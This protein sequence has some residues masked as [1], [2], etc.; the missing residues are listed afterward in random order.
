MMGTEEES[1]QN[2]SQHVMNFQTTL[3]TIESS[4]GEDTLWVP[5]IWDIKET[6]ITK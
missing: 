2:K 4:K 3:V 6:Q 5:V 1:V